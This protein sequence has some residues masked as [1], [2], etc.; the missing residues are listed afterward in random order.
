ML[1]AKTGMNERGFSI[2]EVIIASAIMVIGI[3]G[4]MALFAVA[5]AK[6]VQQGNQA[7][8]CTEYAQDKMEQ[9]LA[10]SYTDTTSQVVGSVTIPNNCTGCGLTPGGNVSPSSPVTGYV[11]YVNPND[12][13]HTDGISGTAA[14]AQ[15][16]REWLISPPNANQVMTITVFVKSQFTADVS[17]QLAPSTTLVAVKQQY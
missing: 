8:R 10:L 4:L 11:D 16:M 15:Y 5:A 13:T 9:L 14:G 2:L 3:S 12:T 6:N 1:K 17:Q 7:T